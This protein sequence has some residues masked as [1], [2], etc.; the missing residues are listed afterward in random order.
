MQN[1]IV[2]EPY[3]FVPP[4]PGTFWVKVLQAYYLLY[5]LKHTWGVHA[6]EYRG[7]EYLRESLDAGHGIV[8]APNHCRL[9]DPL[10]MGMLARHVKRPFYTMGSWHLFMEGR[11]KRWLLRRI[12]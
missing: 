11:F 8:L 5:N 7:A 10:T 1:I 6:F 2:L 3:C 4:Y 12:G 9:F